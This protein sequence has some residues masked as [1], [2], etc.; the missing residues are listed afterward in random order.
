MCQ[1]ETE[2]GSSVLPFR[3]LY[4]PSGSVLIDMGTKERYWKSFISCFRNYL[5]GSIGN[6]IFM[7]R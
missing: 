2:D 4:T 1:D 3:S 7:A 5:C 6:V